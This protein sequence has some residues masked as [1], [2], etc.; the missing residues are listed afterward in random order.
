M[1]DLE[2]YFWSAEE[3][4]RIQAFLNEKGV[5]RQCC[6]NPEWQIGTGPIS[7]PIVQKDELFRNSTGAGI[8]SI[9]VYCLNCGRLSHFFLYVVM[10]EMVQQVIDRISEELK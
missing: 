9:A 2:F 4:E 3:K 10:P 5:K 8:P 1:N 7:Q 6:S